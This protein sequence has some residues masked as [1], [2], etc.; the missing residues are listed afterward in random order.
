MTVEVSST[1]DLKTLLYRT[2]KLMEEI[3]VILEFVR[4]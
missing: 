2:K 1:T 3:F 4:I